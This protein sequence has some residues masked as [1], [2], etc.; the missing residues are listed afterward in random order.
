MIQGGCAI[1]TNNDWEW[2]LPYIYNGTTWERVVPY[3]YNG[4]SWEKIGGAGTLMV[5]FIDS[6]G[7]YILVRS[8]ESLIAQLFD[9]NGNALL[10]KNGNYLFVRK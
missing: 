4:T 1:Y 10:D 2:S 6:N 7:D 8:P 9:S 5:Y 3:V